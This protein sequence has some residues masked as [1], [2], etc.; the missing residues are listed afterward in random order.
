M[1]RTFA[2]LACI[3]TLFLAGCTSES[4]LPNPTGKG[5]LRAINAMPGS[6]NVTFRIEERSLGN[7]D[8]KESTSPANFDDFEYNF[9]FDIRVVDSSD[10]VRIASVLQKVDADR[11]YVFA[12]TGSV[13][14]PTVTTWITDLRQ[15]DGT[16]TVFEAR[17]AHL[18]ATLGDIDVYFDDPANPPSAANL[19]TT[20]SPGNI[21]DIADFDAGNY[22]ITVTAAGD[23]NRVPL[24]T[25]LEV[26]FNAQ[27]SHLIS[28]LDGNE[29]NT[30]PYFATTSTTSGLVLGLPD[31]TFPP[32]IRFIHSALTLE[33]VDIY[34]D[35]LLTSQ[36]AS[37]VAF[38]TFTPDVPT[39]AGATTYYFTPAGSTA[40]TL[41]VSGVT[42]T[43]A[44][45]TGE[46]YLVGDTDA[47][48][49]VFRPQNRASISTAAKISMLNASINHVL[50][51]LYIKERDDPLVEE[52]F[53]SVLR[54][55]S[56]LSSPQLLRAAGSYDI[57]VTGP[58]TK[59][60]LAGPYPV[61]LALG[62]VVI[63]VAADNVDPSAVDILD[64]SLP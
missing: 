62:D 22:V 63:L 33:T 18:S 55:A 13:D 48:Q 50:I 26:A 35:E 60:V 31:A 47:W 64:V 45:A 42:A 14:D 19:V 58:G 57:Y 39:T 46:M 5:V 6:P 32:T 30:A 43:P 41:F 25:S 34:S 15:W 11:D 24:Y 7:I 28:I 38:G 27:S 59:D 4:S 2:F 61:D 37:D 16:E 1:K 20:L 23:A 9:N 40:T 53:P 12:L 21:M 17:F 49:G 52:D 44:G 51:D 56:S 3:G 10:P 36:L 29:I 8:Y 54:I